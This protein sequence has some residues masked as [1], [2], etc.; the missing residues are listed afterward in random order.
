MTP[1]SHNTRKLSVMN[2]EE[3][4]HHTFVIRMW[5]EGTDEQTWRGSIQHIPSGLR[6]PVHTLEDITQ[7][8]NTLLHLSDNNS[9]SEQP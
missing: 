1:P 4:A 2:H 5:L 6:R 9:A 3:Q 8:I 7:F